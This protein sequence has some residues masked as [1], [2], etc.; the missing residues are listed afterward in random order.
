MRG[1][2]VFFGYLGD[3]E[4][5][6]SSVTGD[7]FFRTGDLARLGADGYL[8]LTGRLKDLI[9]RGGVNISP[10]P[11]EDALAAH[12]AVRR[13]AVVGAPDERLGE[14]ICAVVV[15]EG[16]PPELDDLIA[17]V[18]GQGLPRRLWP[19]ALRVVDEMPTTAAGKIRKNVLA[20]RLRVE[21]RSGTLG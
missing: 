4:L 5:Y 13:V 1:P 14:R 18:R 11:I 7:G 3:E 10:L 12:P 20:E 2:G 19:E 15:P 8:H 6:R 21:R 16:D 17:W 9:V